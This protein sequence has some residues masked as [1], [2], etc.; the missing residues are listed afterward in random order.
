MAGIFE[1]PFC[2]YMKVSFPHSFVSKKT[3]TMEKV[4]LKCDDYSILEVGLERLYDIA[5]FIVNENYKHHATGSIPHNI[6]NEIDNIYDDEVI[7]SPNALYYVVIDKGG[8]MIGSIR[9]FK[10]NKFIKTPMEKIFNISPLEKVKNS[11]TSSFW[12]IG[13]FAINSKAGFSTIK[14]FKQLMILAITP[15]VNDNESYMFAET[16]S[17]LLRVMNSLGIETIQLGKSET[18]LASETIPIC[19]SRKGLLPFY[20]TYHNLQ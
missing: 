15:I 16:D 17:H 4:I 20:S 2:V 7:Y 13:R 8:K 11:S 6:N 18:Y 1:I 9:T 12:H 10:W 5:S 14:L 3:R 19:S